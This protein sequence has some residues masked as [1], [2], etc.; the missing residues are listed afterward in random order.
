MARDTGRTD[1]SNIEP[2]RTEPPPAGAQKPRGRLGLFLPFILLL[3]VAVLGTAGWFYIR[4]RATREIDGWLG[5]EAAA[6]R[7][8]TCA[9]RAITGYPF[10]L[11]LRCAS[12]KLARQDGSFTL[13]PIT[14]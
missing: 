9:D 7:S 14:A 11:E 10:R 1:P 6:G 3:V 8:W 13:G 2:P 5:R 12:L 4:D